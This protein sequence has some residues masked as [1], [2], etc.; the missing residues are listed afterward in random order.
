M[1]KNTATI[2]ANLIKKIK[3]IDD[4]QILISLSIHA[5]M[6]VKDPIT[7]K[8]LAAKPQ[9]AQKVPMKAPTPIATESHIL[10]YEFGGKAMIAFQSNGKPSDEVLAICKGAHMRFYRNVPSNPFGNANAF[11]AGKAS[12]ELEAQLLAVA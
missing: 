6:A 2:K 4:D 1:S 9:K 5:G 10:K 3:L 8:T 11:W 7:T 12:D